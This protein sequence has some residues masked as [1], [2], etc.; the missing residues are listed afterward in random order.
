MGAVA[1]KVKLLDNEE[2]TR[3]VRGIRGKAMILLVVYIGL[4]IIGIALSYGVGLFVEK[5][6]PAAS[7]PVFLAMYFVSLWVAWQIAV[8]ITAP[9]A[10]ST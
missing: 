7:L 9:K 5:N 3:P 6:A 1:A 2:I 10:K 8:R 4:M